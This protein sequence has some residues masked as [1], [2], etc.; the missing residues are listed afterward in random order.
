MNK[1]IV[2]TR[3]EKWGTFNGKTKNVEEIDHQHLS[4][5]YWFFYIIHNEIMMFA[6]N[7]IEERFNGQLLDYRPHI[8]FEMEIEFLEKNGYLFWRPDQ[9][10]ELYTKGFIV[11]DGKNVGY[12]NKP[13]KLV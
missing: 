10:T 6:L 1:K 2:Y 7:E 4:N 5:I 11:I 13:K 9:D 8:S 3:P 12:I